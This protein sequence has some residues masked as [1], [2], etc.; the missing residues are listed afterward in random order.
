MPRE[1]VL[2]AARGIEALLDVPS[3]ISTKR[4]SRQERQERT[5]RVK[6]FLAL[7]AELQEGA[8]HYAENMKG[9]YLSKNY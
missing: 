3:A 5:A 1:D 9:A 2:E 4:M 8:L 7:P 6:R